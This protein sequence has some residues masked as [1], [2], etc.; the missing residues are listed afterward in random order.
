MTGKWRRSEAFN[1]GNIY[2]SFMTQTE[3][4]LVKIKWVFRGRSPWDLGNK[5]S[6]LAP[7]GYGY[8]RPSMVLKGDS[9]A[10][11]NDQESQK[12]RET[13]VPQPQDTGYCREMG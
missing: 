10:E 4:P 7:V 11:P 12:S 3:G 6:F 9:D 2:V 8:L 5:K 1:L 13:P